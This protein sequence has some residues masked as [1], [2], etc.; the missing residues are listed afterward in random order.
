MMPAAVAFQGLS[1]WLVH[2]YPEVFIAGG[3]HLA[4]A[5]LTLLFSVNYLLGG[6][7]LLQRRH[8]WIVSR[9]AQELLES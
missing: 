7:R 6:V 4:L 1:W 3:W 2:A 8:R 5:G 9:H